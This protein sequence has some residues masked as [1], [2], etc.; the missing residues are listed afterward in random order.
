MGVSWL[1]FLVG[2]P[3]A[4][5]GGGDRSKGA[6]PWERQKPRGIRCREHLGG[7][8]AFRPLCSGARGPEFKPCVCHYRLLRRLLG[9]PCMTVRWCE[10]GI[11]IV[12]A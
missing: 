11:R 4:G 7:I 6:T 10:L 9:V 3:Q 1:W 12:P 2:K 5:G 8:P